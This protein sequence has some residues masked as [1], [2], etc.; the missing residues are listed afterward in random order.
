MSDAID[1]AAMALGAIGQPVRRK[2]DQRLLTGKGRFADDF[3]I[4]G[5]AHAVMVRSP[6]PHARILQVDGTR[7]KRMPGVLG[8]FSGRDCLADGLAPIPHSPVPSTRYDLKLTGPGGGTIFI[9]PQT[10]LPTDKV[11]HVGEA[12][13]MVV[14]ETL[15]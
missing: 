5:Q 8:V 15:L 11:R 13:A 14:A 4:A 6:Y 2:E 9:G 10:P 1:I 3:S 12:V 7:V